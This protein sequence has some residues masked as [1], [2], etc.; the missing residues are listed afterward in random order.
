MN[1][2]KLKKFVKPFYESKDIMHDLSHIE[3]V[4]ITLDGILKYSEDSYDYNII[5]Y[6]AYFHGFIYSDES[7]I[8]KWLQKEGLEESKINKI[9]KVSWESQKDKSAETLEGKLLH[10]AHMIEGGKVFLVTK[11]L[12]TGSV[13]GQ[14]LEETIKYIEKHILGEGICYFEK[15]RQIYKEAQEYTKDYI[16]KLKCGIN[17]QI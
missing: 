6:A 11:S 12:I 3:R 16:T 8:I 4:L 7:I 13:R 15:T 1:I 17:G 5:V 10:D 9:I 2:A 14:T